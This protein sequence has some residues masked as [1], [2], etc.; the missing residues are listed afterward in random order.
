MAAKYATIEANMFACVNSSSVNKLYGSLFALN[1]SNPILLG[2][3]QY[4]ISKR[5]LFHD[6]TVRAIAQGY[7]GTEQSSGGA[8]NMQQHNITSVITL[9]GGAG[10][11]AN[12]T[13]LNNMSPASEQCSKITEQVI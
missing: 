12:V 2:R 1:P 9:F 7:D 3:N 10:G 5:A 6:G 8:I 11:A 13:A 4:V